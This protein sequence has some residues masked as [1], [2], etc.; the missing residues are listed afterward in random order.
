MKASLTNWRV[1]VFGLVSWAVPFIASLA[2]FSRTGELVIPQPLF[3][4]LMV[5]IGGGVAVWLLVR[6]FR[7]VPP[8]LGTGLAIGGY[9]LA[10]NWV[11]DL[12]VL[13]PMSGMTLA[14]YASDIGLRYLL[15]PIIAA[16]L[17]AV[18]ARRA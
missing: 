5:V 2:F 7:Q 12:L 11:L 4:S 6:V 18:G 9:W 14:A 15:I 1:S 8:S 16:G 10:I 17:G 13:L 3:K